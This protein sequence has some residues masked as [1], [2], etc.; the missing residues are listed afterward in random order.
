MIR[1]VVV[2]AAL[3]AASADAIALQ[4]SMSAMACCAKAHHECAGLKTADDCCQSMGHG[5]AASTATAPAARADDDG[6]AVAAMLPVFA[7]PAMAAGTFFT[8]DSAFKR[9]HDPPHLHPIPLLI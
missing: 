4:F 3:L 9:P 7:I 1:S 5:V 8:A 6:L 2:L